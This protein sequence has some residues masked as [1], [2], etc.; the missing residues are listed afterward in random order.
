VEPEAVWSRFQRQRRRGGI[1]NVPDNL[2]GYLVA[3][4]KRMAKEAY[5]PADPSKLADARRELARRNS[6][7]RPS[8]V[9]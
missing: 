4:A 7:R 3:I 5:G 9:P 8:A 2:A 1:P 6:R